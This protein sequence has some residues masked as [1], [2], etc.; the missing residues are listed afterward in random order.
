MAL[1]ITVMPSLVL[2]LVKV[3]PPVQGLPDG[4]HVAV[5]AQVAVFHPHV[6]VHGAGGDHV[7]LQPQ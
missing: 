5:L 6:L 4:G 2:L 3:V 7:L 1:L